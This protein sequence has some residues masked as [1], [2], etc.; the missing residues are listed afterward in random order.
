MP[1]FHF[2]LE[3]QDGSGH[4]RQG[5]IE[6]ESEAH[7]RMVLEERE[8]DNAAFQLDDGRIAELLDEHGAESL[9]ELPHAA[10]AKAS[11]AE[12]AAFRALPVRDRS[13]LNLHR[14]TKPYRLVKLEQAGGAE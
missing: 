8:R 12:K 6:S 4:F 2:R 13:H 9:D 5:S 11:E 14:Q 10:A 7:A 1:I 3:A